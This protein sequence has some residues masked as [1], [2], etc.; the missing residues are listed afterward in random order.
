M[1]EFTSKGSI[2]TIEEHMELKTTVCQPISKLE[3]SIR[4]SRPSCCAEL[5]RGELLQ[6]SSK[7]TGICKQLFTQDA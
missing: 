6:L 5:K 4:T 3:S 7:F 1:R 2:P